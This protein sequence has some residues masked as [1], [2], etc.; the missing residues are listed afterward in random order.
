MR[1]EAMYHTADPNVAMSS[2]ERRLVMVYGMFSYELLLP[3][4]N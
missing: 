4:K 3:S 1:L 2:A